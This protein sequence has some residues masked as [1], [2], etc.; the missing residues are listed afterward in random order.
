MKKKWLLL[1]GIAAMAVLTACTPTETGPDGL[2]YKVTKAKDETLPYR[3]PAPI[4]VDAMEAMLFVYR[5]N[6]DGTELERVTSYADEMNEQVLVDKLIEYGVLEEGT[7]ILSFEMEGDVKAGP[8]LPEGETL[9]ASTSERIGYLNLSKVP[10]LDA[11]A[12]KVML[13]CIAATFVDNFQLDKVKLLVNGEN[14]KS[15]NI[16]QGDEDYLVF[17]MHYKNVEEEEEEESTEESTDAPA[18]AEV[19][20]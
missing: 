17:D 9:P 10:T 20:E 18:E 15:E 8:G 12:E 7:E 16:T 1:T 4:D 3:G 14:Y 2:P 13:N 19:S 5:G 11:A 6:A